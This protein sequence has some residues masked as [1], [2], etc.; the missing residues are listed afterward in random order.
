MPASAKKK[1]IAPPEPSTYPN[2]LKGKLDLVDIDGQAYSIL[3]AVRRALLK[4]GN[5]R[6]TVDAVL[7]DMKNG[8]YDH[9]IAVAASVVEDP[10]EMDDDD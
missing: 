1:P 7:R 6:E 3:S 10:S 5:D 9:L 8:D 2:L 4:A